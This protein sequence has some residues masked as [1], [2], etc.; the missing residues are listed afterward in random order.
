MSAGSSDEV[1]PVREVRRLHLM[2]NDWY[3]GIRDDIDPIEAALA[4]EFTSIGPDGELRDATESVRAWERRRD[5]YT[6]SSPPVSLELEDVA[7]QRTIYGVHQVTYRKQV[8]VDGEWE[9]FGCS[10][11]LRETD[12]VPTGLQWLHLTETPVAT[13][14]TSDEDGSAGDE[15]AQEA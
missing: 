7:V 1:D 4:P 6:A 9:V 11:W 15:D 8:R 14:P 13:E 10:L 3:T 12:R 2:L 5:E